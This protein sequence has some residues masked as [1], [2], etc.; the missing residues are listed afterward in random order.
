MNRG[1]TEDSRSS[2]HVELKP[3]PVVGACYDLRDTSKGRQTDDMIRTTPGRS[4]LVKP[5]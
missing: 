2:M 1:E 4:V 3:S 5:A